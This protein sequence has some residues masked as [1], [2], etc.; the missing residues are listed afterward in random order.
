MPLVSSLEGRQTYGFSHMSAEFPAAPPVITM[1][2]YTELEFPLYLKPKSEAFEDVIAAIRKS[3]RQPD[4]PL[5]SMFFSK[6]NVDALQTAIASRMEEALGVRLDRQSDW[7]LLLIMRR[8]Y[9]ETAS[10]WPDDVAR[11]ATRLNGL[12]MQI[13]TEAI[14]RNVTRYMTYRNKLPQPLPLP[15]PA[16]ELEGTAY[17][18]GPPVPLP[19]LNAEYEV[20]VRSF[21]ST[22]LPT[23][24]QPVDQAPF[25]TAGPRVSGDLNAAYERSVAGFRS[26]GPPLFVT[27]PPR[28]TLGPQ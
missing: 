11:E 4:T 1:P 24:R 23:T 25:P 16:D 6:E 22:P 18:S 8:V 21:R 10:N 2:P 26:T 3:L 28:E 12:V 20:G 14:S 17:P 19:D 13:S 7:E 15:N 27:T 5:N 9:L